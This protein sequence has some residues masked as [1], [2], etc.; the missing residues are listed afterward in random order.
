MTRTISWI[1]MLVLLTLSECSEPN[2]GSS[3]DYRR[4]DTASSGSLHRAEVQR[5]PVVCQKWI[6][7]SRGAQ[8]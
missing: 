8:Q 3:D 7:D 2:A 4:T 6:A 5:V 1:L